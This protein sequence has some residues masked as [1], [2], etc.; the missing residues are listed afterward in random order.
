M[1]PTTDGPRFHRGTGILLG[2]SA[3]LTVFA[4]LN[5]AYLDWCNKKRERVLRAMAGGETESGEVSVG[6]SG[7][8]G[9]GDESVHFK[10]IT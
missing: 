5:S 4:A 10:Y 2:L 7:V 8:G 9:K 1:F 6:H 3:A